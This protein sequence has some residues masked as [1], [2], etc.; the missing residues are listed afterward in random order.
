VFLRLP[1]IENVDAVGLKG[2][3]GSTDGFRGVNAVATV[4]ACG[5]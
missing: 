1:I 4:V 5:P 2:V 3:I